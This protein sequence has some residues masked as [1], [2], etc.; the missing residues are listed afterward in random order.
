MGKRTQASVEEMTQHLRRLV[1]ELMKTN[2]DRKEIQSLSAKTGIDYSED[3]I[4]LMSTV[5]KRMN[6]VC[7]GY[8]GMKRKPQETSL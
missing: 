5:L 7:T 8:R 1:T 6:T 4:E 2:P 3:P